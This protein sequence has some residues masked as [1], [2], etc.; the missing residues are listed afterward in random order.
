MDSIQLTFHNLLFVPP[1]FN[2]LFPRGFFCP[3]G[4]DCT[5]IRKAA[6]GMS[7]LLCIIWLNFKHIGYQYNNSIYASNASSPPP[8]DRT[9]LARTLPNCTPSWS[10]ELMFQRNP[11]NMTLFS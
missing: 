8:P 6:A 2:L 7:Q 1:G 10:N 4:M 9:F 5:Y 11:W 3:H